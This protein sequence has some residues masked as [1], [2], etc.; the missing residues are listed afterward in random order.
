LKAPGNR[1]TTPVEE[2]SNQL[3]AQECCKSVK[4]LGFLAVKNFRIIN[5]ALDI[6][7][8]DE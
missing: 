1:R 4:K 5:P 3:Q 6:L 8:A 2:T 7:R